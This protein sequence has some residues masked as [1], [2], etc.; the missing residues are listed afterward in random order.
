V[1]QNE[2][3]LADAAAAAAAAAVGGGG[4][5]GERTCVL[6][7]PPGG[8]QASFQLFRCGPLNIPCS[9]LFL[10]DYPLLDSTFTL[11]LA[12]EGADKEADK[13]GK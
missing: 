4:G 3:P 2:V 8:L 6:P 7:P 13:C 1:R 9:A 11:R 12:V 10:S 5:H